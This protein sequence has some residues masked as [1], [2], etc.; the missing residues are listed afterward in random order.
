MLPGDNHW[1]PLS[2]NRTVGFIIQFTNVLMLGNPIQ[3]LSFPNE[4][5]NY[6]RV[7]IILIFGWSYNFPLSSVD[8]MEPFQSRGPST[9]PCPQSDGIVEINCTQDSQDNKSCQKEP[10]P[11]KQG[12][13]VAHL[14]PSL[15]LLWKRCQSER[16][17]L[18]PQM[19]G[20]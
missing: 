2:N 15:E 20:R 11:L 9:R 4:L 3:V 19:R 10:V 12:R 7:K 1:L 16:S 17:V 18:G 6:P 13:P 8:G 14:I 5:E